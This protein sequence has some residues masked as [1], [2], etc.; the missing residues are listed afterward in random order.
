MDSLIR[1]WIRQLIWWSNVSEAFK[2]EPFRSFSS[3]SRVCRNNA[4]IP[5][6][7]VS[8]WEELLFEEP[9]PKFSC[10]HTDVCK[11]KLEEA[12][13]N[14]CSLSDAILEGLSQAWQVLKK[15]DC[16]HD[17]IRDK[18]FQLMSTIRLVESKDRDPLFVWVMNFFF[19]KNS[20]RL[21]ILKVELF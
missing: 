18:T 20:W 10:W 1:K 7:T 13:L 19:T 15:P 9:F 21:V 2:V 4:L 3:G 16:N 5:L 12:N 8:S 14:K 17:G 11:L 6:S